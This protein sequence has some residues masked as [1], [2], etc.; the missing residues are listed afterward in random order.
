MNLKLC[1]FIPNSHLKLF[2]EY[3]SYL[4]E[5]DNDLINY[6]LAY[7]QY[8]CYKY[9]KIKGSEEEKLDF[10]YQNFLVKSDLSIDQLKRYDMLKPN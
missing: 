4:S 5:E 1:Y 10:I 6:Y 2:R 8:L 3:H 7:I 9:E